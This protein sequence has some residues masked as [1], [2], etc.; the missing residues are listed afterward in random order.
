M[1]H[2]IDMTGDGDLILAAHYRVPIDEPVTILA[3]IFIEAHAHGVS[4]GF[5]GNLDGRRNT[6]LEIERQ[7]LAIN[8]WVVCRS[9]R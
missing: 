9:R 2:Q 6:K 3:I 5:V 4:I 8:F 7:F 1:R